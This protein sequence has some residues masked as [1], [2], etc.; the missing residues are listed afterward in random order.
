MK[1]RNK[2]R[3]ASSGGHLPAQQRELLLQSSIAADAVFDSAKVLSAQ[4]FCLEGIQHN[5]L[6]RIGDWAEDLGGELIFWLYSMA[7]TGNSSIALTVADALKHRQPLTIGRDPRITT[8]L[9]ASFFF[10]QVDNTRNDIQPSSRTGSQRQSDYWNKA[11]QQQL[12]HLSVEALST[13]YGTTFLHI[14]LIVV[15][16]ALDECLDRSQTKELVGVQAMQLKDLQK[17]QLRVLIDSRREEHIQ[18]AFSQ[19]KNDCMDQRLWRRL[20]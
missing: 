2:T 1:Q 16:Y 17:I 7:G 6:C 8:F 5:I 4:S 18:Q 3:S 15:L 19:L 11:P 13:L 10:Q 20:D 12:Q 9:G 14:R